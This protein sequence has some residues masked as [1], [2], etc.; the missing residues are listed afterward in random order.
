MFQYSELD[1][2]PNRED[3]STYSLHQLQILMKHNILV[4]I[5]YWTLF[6][7]AM[8]LYFIFFHIKKYKYYL[9]PLVKRNTTKE[10]RRFR[11]LAIQQQELQ[12]T[13]F[14]GSSNDQTINSYKCF[15]INFPYLKEKLFSKSHDVIDQGYES[16][17]REST[18]RC[19]DI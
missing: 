10:I 15:R 5:N 9:I 1:I 14:D 7:V 8:T 11:R 2:Y 17:I 13:A 3:A 16:V 18:H 6:Y 4:S 19:N 12:S